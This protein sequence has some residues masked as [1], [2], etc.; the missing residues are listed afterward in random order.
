MRHLPFCEGLCFPFFNTIQDGLYKAK[1]SDEIDVHRKTGQ[2]KLA[3]KGT[4]NTE[5][6]T[7]KI[8]T[9]SVH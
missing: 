3:T 8:L 7:R 9:A 6:W 5:F 1:L 4:M 2:V